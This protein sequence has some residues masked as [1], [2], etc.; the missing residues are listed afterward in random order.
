[1]ALPP[2]NP[3]QLLDSYRK[4]DAV[5]IVCQNNG[6]K[7]IEIIALNNQAVEI[8][9][10]SANEL[11]GKNLAVILPQRI[12][13]TLTEFIEYDSDH[14][15][16]LT[17]LNKVRNFAVKKAN[18]SEQEFK[19]RIIRGES[20]DRNPWFHL[21]LVDEKELLRAEAFRK[22]L[23]ENF[24]GHEIIDEHSGLPN[25][26]SVIRDLEL[27]TYHLRDKKIAAS[28]A[29]VDINYHESLLAEYG[30]DIST[31]L[32]RHIGAI[33]KQKL[34]TEDLVGSLSER[35]IGLS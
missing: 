10:F 3:S 26:L 30:Q 20:V 33:C 16:L 12:H 13:S 14:N 7:A 11:V 17:V 4:T 23:Q 2:I 34:R 27:I 1:M 8:T 24:K 6:A 32:Y 31:Q 18:G 21:V 5:F 19:L 9:G 25:R 35:S 28:F 29:I 22:A 15:D